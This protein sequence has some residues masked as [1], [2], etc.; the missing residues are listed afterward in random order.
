MDYHIAYAFCKHIAKAAQANTTTKA[1]SKSLQS[2]R[3]KTLQ[4][5]DRKA[6]TDRRPACNSGFKKFGVQWLIEHSTS[7]Q[8]LCWLDSFVLR[9]P[10]LLKPAKRW[11]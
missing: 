11:Q 4:T 2:H 6:T 10:Q 5:M 7:H 9:N 8:I 3:T 1:L